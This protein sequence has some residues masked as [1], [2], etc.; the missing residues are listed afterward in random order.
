M[1]SKKLVIE[2]TNGE[3]YD[4]TVYDT[5]EEC[6]EP[7]MYVTFAAE[8]GVSEE[9]WIKLGEETDYGA[10]QATFKD[11]SDG[12]VYHIL[13]AIYYKAEIIQSDNQTIHVWTP[14]KDGG[15]DHTETFM[16]EA[17]TGWEAE[18]VPNSG[19]N[20]GELTAQKKK[21]KD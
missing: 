20:A 5:K 4:I 7:N 17:G 12:K 11:D 2:Q 6:P 21:M 8:N 14:Q 10:T 15:T 19:Y 16:V 13:K 3:T 18:V 1:P 9:G